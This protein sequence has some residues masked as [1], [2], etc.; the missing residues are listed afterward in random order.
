MCVFDFYATLT[1]IRQHNSVVEQRQTKRNQSSKYF[2]SFDKFLS[3]NQVRRTLKE[4]KGGLDHPEFCLHRFSHFK[5]LKIERNNTFLRLKRYFLLRKLIK[6]LSSG[7]HGDQRWSNRR[8]FQ[9]LQH[10]FDIFRRKS[11]CVRNATRL[12]NCDV[13]VRASRRGKP[14]STNRCQGYGIV[15]SKFRLIVCRFMAAWNKWT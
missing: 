5:P 3:W 4:G 6:S 1:I 7:C 12:R 15:S 9:H 14:K 2:I 10:F 8:L 11:L 13:T